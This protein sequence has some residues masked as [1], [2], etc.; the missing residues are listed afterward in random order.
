[1]AGIIIGSMII[2][3][4][5]FIVK[6]LL[7]AQISSAT[8]SLLSMARIAGIVVGLAIISV[9]AFNGILFYAEPG[10]KYH[11]RTIFGQE[12]MVKDVGYNA[13]W[14]GKN[15][16]WKNA[17]TVQSSSSGGEMVNAEGESDSTSV[18]LPPQT[19]VFLDQVDTK[20]S[21]T[22]RFLLPD[23]EE[24]FLYMARQYR[25]PENLL[26]TEL[27]PAFQETLAANAALMT[28][29]EYF[30]GGKTQFN[31]EFEKQMKE[32]VFEVRRQIVLKNALRQNTGS[33][34]ASLG[35]DQ[36]KFGDDDEVVYQ[37]EKVLDSTGQ[38]RKKI[39]AFTQFGIVVISARVTDVIPNNAFQ[40]RMKS[41]QNASAERAV[42]IEERTKEEQARLWAIA[43]GEREV[44]EKQAEAKVK[45]ISATT[46]AETERQLVITAARQQKDKAEIDKQTAEIK[47]EQARLDSEA[48]K[49][50]ADAA[51]YEKQAILQADN[52]LQQKLDAFIQINSSWAD[53]FSQRKVPTTIF[54]TGTSETA[55]N[56]NDVQSFMK[57]MTMKAAQD[58]NLDMTIGKSKANELTK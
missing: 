8:K 24:S 2:V 28:A 46:N 4:S 6:P 54:G 10:F 39:Q 3:F 33:A 25:S 21:A 15:N 9:S 29:E 45:Q 47:L 17:M 38:P 58:L 27:I 49:I 52:A 7:P 13:Y 34:N 56:D 26:R 14:F 48:K 57:L 40:E 55:N 32:G 36:T 11:V 43:K 30:S 23:D 12:K 5:I 18:N 35:T 42:K 53:A 31:T 22:V 50:A 37:V 16:A 41:K 20:T 51:A 44:A 19:L 1:M